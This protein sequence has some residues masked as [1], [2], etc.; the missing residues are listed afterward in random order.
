M[1][2][3]VQPRASVPP[4]RHIITI[5]FLLLALIA[6][7]VSGSSVRAQTTTPPTD[8]GPVDATIQDLMALYDVPGVAV[9]LIKD[10]KVI[11]TRGYGVRNTQTQQPVTEDTIFAIG[12]VSK[13]FTALDIAQL[14]DAGKLNL[15]APVITYLPDF[16]LSDPTATR[17]LTLRHL[18]S[19]TSGVPP[20]DDWYTTPARDRKQIVDDMASVPITALP[21]KVWQYTNQNF[22][23]PAYVLQQVT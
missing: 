17:Q 16:K 9:G 2:T 10:G 22:V 4:P 6:T 7:A 5:L 20:F 12:S 15:D 11:Y 8:F 14:V 21:G 19:H 18:L 1:P 3:L 13:S 23:V